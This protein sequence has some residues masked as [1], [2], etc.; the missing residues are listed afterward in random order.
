[1]KRVFIKYIVDEK[2]RD[3]T[4]LQICSLTRAFS[5]SHRQYM[6]LEQTSGKAVFEP[7]QE[8]SGLQGLR[9]G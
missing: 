4:S 7:R 9:P 2:W 5:V 6:E 1:M 8:K 3:Q